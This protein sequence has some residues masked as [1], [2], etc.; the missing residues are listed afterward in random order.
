MI[1]PHP[2]YPSRIYQGPSHASRLAILAERGAGCQVA[3]GGTAAGP[4]QSLRTGR[5]IVLGPF[6]LLLLFIIAVA[7]RALW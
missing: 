7:L 4:S 3:T 2:D 6:C 1:M 5:T